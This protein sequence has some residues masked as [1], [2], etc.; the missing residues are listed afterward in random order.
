M[1][2]NHGTSIMVV[3]GAKAPIGHHYRGAMSNTHAAPIFHIMGA[4]SPGANLFMKFCIS[5]ENIMG[6]FRDRPSKVSSRSY[7][8]Q[9]KTLTAKRK[10]K[11]E[12]F[13]T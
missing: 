5:Y 13:V 12:C 9:S 3:N 2:I 6:T 7:C 8:I 1:S 10:V 4:Y 11:A